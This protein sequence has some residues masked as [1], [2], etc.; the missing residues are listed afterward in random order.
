MSI[1]ITGKRGAD[2]LGGSSTGGAIASFGNNRNTPQMFRNA[3][4][5]LESSFDGRQL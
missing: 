5:Y 2:G 1:T 4:R 3:A